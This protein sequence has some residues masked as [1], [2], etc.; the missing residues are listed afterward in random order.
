V[1]LGETCEAELTI[2]L[3]FQVVSTQSFDGSLTFSGA[4]SDGQMIL[5]AP[6][7]EHLVVPV[8][9]MA[10]LPVEDT[11]RR[12]QTESSATPPFELVWREP[13][14]S[15]L[16]QIWGDDVLLLSLDEEEWQTDASK[17]LRDSE[18]TP[19][20]TQ[21]PNSSGTKFPRSQLK[22][23]HN[24]NPATLIPG[25]ISQREYT[26]Y[27]QTT[28]QAREVGVH[29]VEFGMDYLVDGQP[30]GDPPLGYGPWS[31]DV[32]ADWYDCADA[33]ISAG[34]GCT[35]PNNWLGFDRNL[36]ITGVWYYRGIDEHGNPIQAE[37]EID[38]EPE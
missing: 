2:L 34:E 30:V 31:A 9:G 27:F 26:C 38:C 5:K 28:I 18:H 23:E 11:S 4:L 13:V 12:Q 37:A 16:A 22:V 14:L 19:L 21:Q 35:D 10:L 36:P 15:G 32:F 3:A 17:V 20:Q 7:R 25:G 24:P 8:N 29:I 1:P 33:F 6:E